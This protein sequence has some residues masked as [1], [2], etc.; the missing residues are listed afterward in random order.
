M[1]NNPVNG[2]DPDGG[3]F[4]FF[5]NGDGQIL[6]DRNSTA[7]SIFQGGQEWFNIGKSYTQF[8]GALGSFYETYES[9]GQ[10]LG[11]PLNDFYVK[12]YRNNYIK[13]LLK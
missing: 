3:F 4:D 1:G 13:Q 10:L 7:S 5:K 11:R 8:D 9:A 6:W 12:I 2:V